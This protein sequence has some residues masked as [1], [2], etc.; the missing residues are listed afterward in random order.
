MRALVYDGQLELRA[1]Y[2]DPVPPA[3][4]ALIRVTLA[5]ICNTDLEITRSYMGFNGVLGHEFVGVVE[6]CDD[7]ALVG[8]RVV[9]EINCYCG[10]CPTCLAGNPTHCPQRT[11]LG[12]YGR[13]GAMA[14]YC[15]LPT[16]NLHP[17][18]VGDLNQDCI[19]N[20]FDLAIFASHWLECTRDVCP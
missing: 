13:D 6:R 2:P 8:H 4:E 3:A 7:P 1:D 10:T 18:P 5:G 17:I 16:H 15:V 12:I 9:G 20:F 19:V 14:D 11:T